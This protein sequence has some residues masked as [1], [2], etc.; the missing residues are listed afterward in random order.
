MHAQV[1]ADA[2]ADAGVEAKSA[3]SVGGNTDASAE[4]DGDGSKYTSLPFCQAGGMLP[5]V[6]FLILP[7]AP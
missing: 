7:R 5:F 4:P 6:V 3:P 2:G 1:R